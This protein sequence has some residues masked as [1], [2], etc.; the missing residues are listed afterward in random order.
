MLILIFTKVVC[1]YNSE[2]FRVDLSLGHN[3]DQGVFNRSGL[4]DWLAK[5]GIKVFIYN[6]FISVIILL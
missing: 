4:A 5:H 2:I 1:S 3:N 6:G